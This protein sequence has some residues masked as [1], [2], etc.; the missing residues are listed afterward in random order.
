M[1]GFIPK[2]Y[3]ATLK[4]SKRILKVKKALKSLG[5]DKNMVEFNYQKVPFVKSTKTRTI[6]CTDNHQQIYRKGKDKPFILVFEDDIYSKH[7]LEMI[8]TQL[9]NV[10]HF[11]KKNKDW[12]IIYLG[13]VYM[14]S[15]KGMKKMSRYTPKEIYKIGNDYYP[16]FYKLISPEGGGIDT[17]MAFKSHMGELN[18]YCLYPQIIYQ[19]SIFAFEFFSDISQLYTKYFNIN[20]LVII[21]FI[22]LWYICVTSI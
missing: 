5:I 17:F 7:G 12:D 20:Q 8:K 9:N 15:K 16:S 21:I 11:I 10:K 3:I 22:I 6:S 4:N 2:I 19:Y 1:W 14:I 13:H 18:S